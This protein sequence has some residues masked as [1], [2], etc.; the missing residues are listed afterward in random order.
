MSL[1]IHW[2]VVK[3]IQVHCYSNTFSM[4]KAVFSSILHLMTSAMRSNERSFAMET[5]IMSDYNLMM[6][7]SD[8]FLPSFR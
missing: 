7:W 2:P 4:I 3:K 1:T 8:I 6:K 5:S